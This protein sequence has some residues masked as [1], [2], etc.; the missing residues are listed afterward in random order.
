ML[1]GVL[2]VV[3]IKS[4][5]QIRASA[6]ALKIIPAKRYMFLSG[7]GNFLL[8]DHHGCALGWFGRLGSVKFKI[9]EKIAVF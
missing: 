7:F 5:M 3:D 9:V 2:G 1:S 8:S 6:P 4:V